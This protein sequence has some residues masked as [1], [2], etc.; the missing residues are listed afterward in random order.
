MWKANEQRHGQPGPNLSRLLKTQF[1][2]TDIENKA[3]S[4]L[5]TMRQGNQ[6]VTDHW[7][8]FRLIATETNC[9]DQTLQRLLLKSFNKKI[10]DAWAQVDQD[11]QSTEE[12]A[13]WAVKKVNKLSYVQTMQST[14]TPRNYNDQPNRNSNGTFRPNQTASEPKGDPMDLDAS[15]KKRY[16]N[17]S[18]QEY[19]RRK[20]EN[21]CFKYGRKGHSI[22]K[23]FL[24]QRRGPGQPRIR[25]ME[26]E[27]E[28]ETPEETLN[29]ESP[30]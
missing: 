15:T 25:E 26:V 8:Q 14:H 21:L 28:P 6:T 10:Q 12:L 20:K 18:K 16:L 2:D 3:R 17:L 1:G 5:E 11:M 7:N 24:N 22:G 30:Q 29:E 27:T 19:E 13:N 23:C 9:D 4:K